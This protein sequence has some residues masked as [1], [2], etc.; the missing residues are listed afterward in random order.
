LGDHVCAQTQ[1]SNPLHR[2]LKTGRLPQ[3]K[4]EEAARQ[5]INGFQKLDPGEFIL[6]QLKKRN[7]M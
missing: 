4:E 1:L 5:T 6:I 2:Y 3:A 7:H